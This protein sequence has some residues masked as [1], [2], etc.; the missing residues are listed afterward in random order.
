MKKADRKQIIAVIAGFAVIIIW[1][2]VNIARFNAIRVQ[3]N[4]LENEQTRISTILHEQGE[5]LPESRLYID[6]AIELQ[7]RITRRLDTVLGERFTKSVFTIPPEYMP[8][9]HESKKVFYAGLSTDVRAK[10]I[11]QMNMNGMKLK[12][13]LDFG[14]PDEESMEE[15]I[16]ML[17][18]IEQV[19]NEAVENGL[20]TVERIHQN[21]TE[22]VTTENGRFTFAVYRATLG[23]TGDAMNIISFID[24]FQGS[25][26]RREKIFLENISIE[27]T[28]NHTAASMDFLLISYKGESEPKVKTQKKK[29]DTPGK[30][31]V[32]DENIEPIGI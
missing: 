11:K 29:P 23:F 21:P 17:Y 26:G 31:K 3:E 27:K 22:V 1:N 19:L 12:T 14:K 8:G 2:A 5:S 24:G 9:K 16:S 28:E 7:D 20:G 4:N 25:G 6:K 18:L 32:S 15:N 30:K 13:T 10:L